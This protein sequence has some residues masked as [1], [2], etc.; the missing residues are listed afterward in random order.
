MVAGGGR[1]R[2]PGG[3]GR[4]RSSRRAGGFGERRIRDGPRRGDVGGA[5]R[6]A[7]R[8][9]GVR[10][11]RAAG[12]AWARRWPGS[13]RSTPERSTASPPRTATRRSRP[14]R[15]GRPTIDEIG[16]PLPAVE[17]GLRWLR[18]N[19]PPPPARECLVHG[20]F[21][22]GNLIVDE[23]GL[24]AVIDWELCHV[25]RS[26]RGHRLAVRPLVAVR[27]R[28]SPGRRAWE[29]LDELLAAYEAAGGDAALDPSGS[30]G[31]RRWATS[32]GR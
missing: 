3:E 31:G 13:T 20:D 10:P 2:G 16:E 12:P 18:L 19:P 28:R 17:A 27:Q 9:A 6:A 30:G 7:A 22:L 11:L 15:C 8:G 32:S 21:R 23:S 24:A 26:G 25:G 1:R 29:T 14:A 4:S 5:A